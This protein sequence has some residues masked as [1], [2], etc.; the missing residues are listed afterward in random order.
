MLDALRSSSTAGHFHSL[1]CI[2][3][4]AVPHLSHNSLIFLQRANLARGQKPLHAAVATVAFAL[5]VCLVERKKRLIGSA[6]SLVC[7]VH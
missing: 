3:S 2:V 7:L 1:W 6:A 5:G 4:G